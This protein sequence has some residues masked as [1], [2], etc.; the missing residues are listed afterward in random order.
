MSDLP[1]EI[2]VVAL[3]AGNLAPYAGPLITR[4]KAR[5]PGKDPAARGKPPA[6]AGDIPVLRATG[7][8][9]SP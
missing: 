7:T 6:K 8:E 5:P 2:A 3:G 4:L 1:L 9:G